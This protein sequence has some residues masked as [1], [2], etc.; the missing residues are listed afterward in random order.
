[1]IDH[2]LQTTKMKDLHYVCFSQGCT[3]LL[4]MA[5]LKPEYNKKVRLAI[6]FAPAA[7]MKHAKG[8]ALFAYPIVTY[9]KVHK[10]NFSIN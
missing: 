6:T 2:T 1:M 3:E 4:V 8:L 9:S 7:Y 10:C 5:S